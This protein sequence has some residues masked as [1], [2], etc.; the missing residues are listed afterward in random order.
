VGGSGSVGYS[1]TSTL[2]VRARSPWKNSTGTRAPILRS[3]IVA[4]RS[5]ALLMIRPATFVMTS[6]ASRPATA[7]GAPAVTAPT[8]APS[9]G[10]FVP[11]RSGAFGGIS[12]KLVTLTPMYG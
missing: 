7:A 2:A 3:A 12:E 8:S 6:P 1:F 4:T 11:A 9:A 5:A 10:S